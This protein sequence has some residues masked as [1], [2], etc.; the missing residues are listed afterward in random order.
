MYGKFTT[1]HYLIECPITSKYCQH[2]REMLTDEELALDTTT[3]GNM[4]RAYLYN[5]GPII[6]RPH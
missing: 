6:T 2:I 1:A 5:I 3:Q 4:L